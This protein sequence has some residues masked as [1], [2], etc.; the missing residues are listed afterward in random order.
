M[1]IRRGQAQWQRW[2]TT[3]K[4]IRSYRRYLRV[5]RV[6]APVSMVSRRDSIE[7][8]CTGDHRRIWK[9]SVKQILEGVERRRADSIHED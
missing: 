8:M 6:E 9:S 4:V 1:E 2:L 5:R 3:W 7:S